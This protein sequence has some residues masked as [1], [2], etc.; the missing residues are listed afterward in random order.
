M[1]NRMSLLPYTADSGQH[2]RVFG[3]LKHLV[4]TEKNRMRP[5]LGS[6]QP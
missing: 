2:S 5:P 3:Y 6:K 1:M 4:L